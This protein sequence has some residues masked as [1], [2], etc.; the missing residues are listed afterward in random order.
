MKVLGISCGHD[1]N[2][3]IVD[4]QEILIHLE[5][6]RFSRRKHDAGNVDD[7]INIALDNLNITFD[8]IDLVASSVPVWPEYGRSG[9]IVSGDLYTSIFEYSEHSFQLFGRHMPA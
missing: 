7:L 8:D 9:Q 1:A 6:E 4:E 5:K 3:C 2:I